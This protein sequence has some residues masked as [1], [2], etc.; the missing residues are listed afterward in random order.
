MLDTANDSFWISYERA[1]RSDI[2]Q[3]SVRLLVIT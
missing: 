1:I 2:L 3:E